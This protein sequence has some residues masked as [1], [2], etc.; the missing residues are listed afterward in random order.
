MP[1]PVSDRP[2]GGIHT[3]VGVGEPRGVTV[4]VAQ[5]APAS[6]SPSASSASSSSPASFGCPVSSMAVPHGPDGVGAARRRVR[7]DLLGRG[8]PET[9]VD[10]AVLVLSE[11]LSNSCRHA[12]PLSVAADDTRV[13]ADWGVDGRGRVT[14]SVTDGGGPTRPLP[15]TPSVTARGG[16]GLAI[17]TALAREWGVEQDGGEVTVW[18]VL[19]G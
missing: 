17:I 14:V 12:R 1:W 16:R 15:A 11:L 5:Q 18:A 6:S 13:R 8:V 4:V 9:A 3:G 2:A 10:D 19:P 7:T